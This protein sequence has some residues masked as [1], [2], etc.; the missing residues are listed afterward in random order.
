MSVSRQRLP[1]PDPQ[2]GSILSEAH[3]RLNTAVLILREVQMHLQGDIPLTQDWGADWLADF[4]TDATA[5]RDKLYTLMHL[6]ETVLEDE[7]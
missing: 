3:G 4:I 1:K 6:D 5:T 2:F 7:E